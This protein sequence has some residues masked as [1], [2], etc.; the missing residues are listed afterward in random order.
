MQPQRIKTTFYKIL[1]YS[2]IITASLFADKSYGQGYIAASR[3][4]GGDGIESVSQ[5]VVNNGDSYVF[6]TSVN[7][8]S[9]SN[10][11]PITIGTYKGLADMVVT[12]L[13]ANGVIIWSR[14]LGGN[15]DD[16]SNDIK[17]F[18]GA[19]YITGISESSNYPVTDNS[20]LV[21]L[22]APVYTK[23][24]S[25][26]GA[27]EF[28]TYLQ[29]YNTS[30]RIKITEGVVYLYGTKII[31]STN[32]DIYITKFTAASNT[33]INSITFGGTNIE[34]ISTA[35]YWSGV[36]GQY[37]NESLNENFQVQGGIIYLV[38][39]TRSSDFPVTNGGVFSG[40]VK[41]VYVKLNNTTGVI[42]FATY[43]GETNNNS[44][45]NGICLDNGY[46]YLY[47]ESN[48]EFHSTITCF[49]S[50]TNMLQYSKELT[51]F[52]ANV[53]VQ[54][55]IIYVSS[56]NYFN[57]NYDEVFTKL[58]ANNGNEI[59]SVVLASAGGGEMAVS[60][61]VVNGD[62]YLLGQ[63]TY[64]LQDS[65]PTGFP[66]TNGFYPITNRNL[67][68]TLTKIGANN[69]ICF[70]TYL[71]GTEAGDGAALISNSLVVDNSNVYLSGYIS[72]DFFPVTITDFLGNYS[73][74]NFFWAKFEMSPTMPAV[75]DNLLP[76]T[77]TTCKN[78]IATQIMGDEI[79]FP[80]NMMPIVYKNGIPG[81]QNAIPLK[82]QWQKANSSTGPW[83]DIIGG[84]EQNY[85]PITG[86]VNQYYRRQAF[87]SV[88]GGTPISISSIAEVIINSNTAPDITLGN[89]INTCAGS[90]VTLGGT[91]TA[92][93]VS[94]A[95]IASYLWAPT[96]QTFTPNANVSNPSVTPA[97]NTVY[98]VTV[99]DNN[100]CKK[101][102]LQLVNAYA[103]NA[104]LDVSSCVGSIVRIGTSAIAGLP[105]VTYNWVANPADPTMSCN[106]CAQ[107]DVHPLIPTT[108][109]LTLTIPKTGGGIC[110]TTDAVLV[111]PI[112]APSNADFAGPDRTV[113]AGSVTMLGTS[114]MAG[115]TYR[116]TP[117][118]F[119]NSNNISNPICTTVINSSFPN[120]TVY[121]VTATKAGCLFE[122]SVKVTLVGAIARAGA[123]G[124]G[125]RTLGYPDETPTINE[126]YQWMVVSGVGRIIGATNTPQINVG[127]SIGADVT[128][129]LTVSLNGVG[130]TDD[131]IVPVCPCQT[132]TIRVLAQFGCPNYNT[133]AGNVKLVAS[134]TIP[135]TF[136]WSPA[137][138]LSNTIG[139]TVTLTDNVQRI[140]TVSAT[141]IIDTS[142]HCI[143]S[144]S[145][146]NSS[147]NTAPVFSA[148]DI[149]SCPGVGVSIG[150]AN[151]AG[152]TY[153]WEEETLG[154]L[155]STANSNPT[156]TV[157]STSIFPVLVTNTLTGCTLKDTSTVTVVEL[158]TNIAGTD[159][160]ICGTGGIAQLGLQ[161]VAGLT[162]SWTPAGGLQP[163][164]TTANPTI[165][166]TNTTTF[167]VVGT[168]NSTGCSVTDDVTVT[169]SPSIPAFSFTP[170]M[171]CPSTSGAL[172][173][174]AGPLGMATYTWSPNYLVLNAN[175][176]GPLATTQSTPP[177]T[178]TTYTLNVSNTGGCTSSASVLFTPTSTSPVA[179][180]GRTIC[181]N[182]TAQLGAAAQPGIYSW[183][184]T[185]AAAGSLNS[186]SISNPM[187]MP[188]AVGTYKFIVSKLTAGCTTKDS[189]I[190][191]VTE[192]ILPTIPS[193]II[194]QNTC[195]PI[196]TNSNLTGTQYFW[197]PTTRLSNASIS[198]PIACVTT[199]SVAYTLTAVGVNGCIASQN[200]F[201][202][203]NPSPSH[204]V[205]VAPIAACV[206]TTGLSLNPVI[207]PAG[208]YNY[209]WSSS[210][211]L[212][213][214]YAPNPVVSLTTLG[215]K[216]YNVV[217]TNNSTGCATTASTT[218]TTNTCTPPI[219]LVSFTAE[220]QDKTVLLSWVVSEEINVL[221]Y[222]IEFSTDGRNF[223][224]I[225]TKAATNSASYNLVHN[226]P[227]LGINYY[228]LKMID[229]DGKISYSD[230][231]T[232]NFKLAGSLT[233]Y[234][235][236]ANN[237]L[238]IT[239]AAGSINKTATISVIA[240]D[241]KLMYQKNINRLSQTEMLD[242]S[243]LANGC[244]I[245]RI[246]TNKEIINKSVVVYR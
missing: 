65:Y 215:T 93:G 191:H 68:V 30:P 17:Y 181:R 228:R 35:S 21:G 169:V 226:T 237:L 242:V 200:M 145:V 173:L 85:T 184:Q 241:G 235:N 99:T 27:I 109:I 136:T 79:I 54:S 219:K 175:S 140:Y 185:P 111:T 177:S 147:S 196:G 182:A 216:N 92:T 164:N 49:N 75:P 119:L 66:I 194:C 91:P 153:I 44:L 18:N 212:S 78:G 220:P 172:G 28:S 239:F 116:W 118:Y 227:V 229:R 32:E 6:G 1:L 179:G 45:P 170:V 217:V 47:Y 152:Y 110:S 192:F 131:V 157:N 103:A 82:Y 86:L 61:K 52:N 125:P 42:Q 231:R 188:T 8:D 183:T 69:K 46:A 74:P 163:N 73:D 166:V 71:G 133:N 243:K 3:Y 107:P 246:L 16:Y 120:P 87:V 39:N 14:F 167:T 148:Q 245:I 160:K 53:V 201:I 139:D 141:S 112:S 114:P 58:D 224:P 38:C 132:P 197:S 59:F 24:N 174:P 88:C 72:A 19:L 209:L 221:K 7:T 122:D 90:S 36:A 105:G 218:V 222:E 135:S 37:N 81:S 211:G 203:V 23:L 55:G 210:N 70:S 137:A 208:S 154:T 195:V 9:T 233:I 146:N 162:Y 94:G 202:T 207:S 57:E 48:N 20:T 240:M 176:N 130:C 102:G 31:S 67:L 108:Y 117:S 204:T 232:V 178:A 115:F 159:V 100:G 29:D 123:D 150:Q 84:I 244:Y 22:Q 4:L 13:D 156:A 193:P 238:Y 101:V 43:L 168:N 214:I 198:N 77:Q 64:G 106:T 189:V 62:A 199:N 190:I 124:C 134:R 129:R 11:F 236:P 25:N 97:S 98:S 155:S 234:P 60:L 143:S 104:G 151:V 63:T 144:I 225:G 33:F 10:T 128:Y 230:I 126:T 56:T 138:G 41:S 206:G 96:S 50:T 171:Y 121:R 89:I 40:F 34:H 158:P 186:Y 142:E 213:N 83:E 15:L 113:C 76:S 187:F 161:P 12:K 95:T 5:I 80:S 127:A 165:N 2:F 223:W 26:T 180:N 51:S 205:T 149:F